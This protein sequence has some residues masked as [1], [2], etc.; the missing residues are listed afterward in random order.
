[1]TFSPYF[2]ITVVY[3]IYTCEYQSRYEYKNISI[4]YIYAYAY[5]VG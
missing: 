3:Y 5:M 2:L 1:M 4:I